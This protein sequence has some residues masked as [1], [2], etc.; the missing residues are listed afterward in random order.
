MDIS[1]LRAFLSNGHTYLEPSPKDRH[2]LRG[3]KLNTLLSYNAA[4]KKFLKF[5]SETSNSHF[6]LPATDDEI[7]SFT[8]WAGRNAETQTPQEI[9]ATTVQK[10]LFGLQAW[11]DYH[12]LPYPLNSKRRVAI[13]LRASAKVDAQI[14]PKPRKEAIKLHHL[15][16]LA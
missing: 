9:A 12:G 14:Q 15:L 10:Y 2:F 3:F 6:V 16:F 11:H 4:V 8:F 1:K 7:V 5:K 13:M